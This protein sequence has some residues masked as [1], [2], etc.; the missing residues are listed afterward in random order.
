[1]ARAIVCAIKKRKRTVVIDWRYGVLVWFWR[2]I[3]GWL[4]VRLRIV[5][6]KEKN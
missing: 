2:L 4:W 1:V 3:P 5:K 6:T